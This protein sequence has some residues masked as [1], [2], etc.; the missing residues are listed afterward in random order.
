MLVFFS[1]GATA[2]G[3]KLCHWSKTSGCNQSSSMGTFN[4][5]ANS[6]YQVLLR[7]SLA[8]GG[9]ATTEAGIIPKSFG[10]SAV[11]DYTHHTNTAPYMDEDTLALNS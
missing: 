11:V 7:F 9:E 4:A 6:V 8:P 3:Q 10:S 5:S 2:L 1:H